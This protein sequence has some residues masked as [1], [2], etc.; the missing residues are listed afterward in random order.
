MLLASSSSP[1]PLAFPRGQQ[2][3]ARGLIVSEVRPLYQVT[4]IDVPDR[5]RFVEYARAALPL[6]ERPRGELRGVSLGTVEVVERDWHPP[7]LIIHR[8]PSQEAFRDSYESEE[9]EPLRSLRQEA[10]ESKLVTFEGNAPVLDPPG[11]GRLA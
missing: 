5:D 11:G 7:L 2:R 10:T 3:D 8:W 4:E 6:V 1:G 9:Y